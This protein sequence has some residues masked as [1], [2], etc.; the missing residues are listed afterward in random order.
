MSTAFAH[1]T[2]LPFEDGEL[3]RLQSKQAL[4]AEVQIQEAATFSRK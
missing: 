3:G 1:I 4:P 2:T